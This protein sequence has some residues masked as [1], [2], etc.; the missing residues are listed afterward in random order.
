[1]NLFGIVLLLA[2][3][4]AALIDFAIP[5]WKTDKYTR[6]ED[7]YKYLH[8]ATRG[9]EHAVP[10]KNAAK[11]WLDNEWQSLGVALKNEATWEHLCPDGSIGR[12]NLRPFKDSGGKT[13]DLLDA[14][15]QSA[16]EYKTESSKFIN[17]W[18][19]LG[20]RL[21]KRGF[22]NITYKEWKRLD[23]EMKKKEYPAIHHS[24]D[25]KKAYRPAY[26]ILTLEQ[27]KRLI[28]S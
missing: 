10:S 18:A 25:Y 6:I 2:C 20:K 22:D 9:G 23:G 27:R 19:E 1:M 11:K 3:A 28:P 24:E 14:F 21:K 12:L 13:D 16:R 26:R 17:A 5:K 8:Q 4:P 7:A 15:L